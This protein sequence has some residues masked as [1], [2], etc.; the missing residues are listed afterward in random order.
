MEVDGPW[1]ESVN[2]KVYGK[3]F[4]LPIVYFKD[5]LFYAKTAHVLVR[6]PSI[7]RSGFNTVGIF[8]FNVVLKI[9]V[10]NRFNNFLFWKVSTFSLNWCVRI[11]EGRL[12]RK[13]VE[14]VTKRYHLVWLWLF[15]Y[16]ILAR[17]L[18]NYSFS[19]ILITLRVRVSVYIF[20]YCKLNRNY[21]KT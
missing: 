14:S 1:I 15:S 20:N 7:F 8:C 10:F 5:R 18:I 12:F 3:H 21:K 4:T 16:Y 19:Y 13:F 2:M 6:R 9:S 11:P 17:L